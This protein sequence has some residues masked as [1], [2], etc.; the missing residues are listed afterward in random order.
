LRGLAVGWF[1]PLLALALPPRGAWEETPWW[2]VFVR[3][4]LPLQW[5]GPVATFLVFRRLKYV[6]RRLGSK[7]LLG[8][9]ALVGSQLPLAMVVLTVFTWREYGRDADALGYLV[10]RPMPGIGA[11][12]PMVFNVGELRWVRWEMFL[13]MPGYL[14]MAWPVVF[15][16]LALVL[17]VEF[18]VV[19]VRL[20]RRRGRGEL[21][22]YCR[23]LVVETSSLK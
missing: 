13:E 1:V 15:T 21:A 23:G 5:V 20:L 19:L 6:A 3:L 4:A 10:S 17:L 7:A 9:S 16:A 8:Q 18:A 11:P 22:A 14:L 12:W 2:A